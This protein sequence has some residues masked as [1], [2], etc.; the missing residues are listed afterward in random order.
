MAFVFATFLWAVKISKVSSYL[1]A[2]C[3]LY[4]Y[5]KFVFPYMLNFLFPCVGMTR[6]HPDPGL[7]LGKLNICLLVKSSLINQLTQVFPRIRLY[8]FSWSACIYVNR[9]IHFFIVLTHLLMKRH[10][11]PHYLNVYS[12]GNG[13]RS[14]I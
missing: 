7:V 8:I 11:L 12:S 13:W 2:V 14:H 1:C 10:S 9:D 6:D 5:V 3:I 4:I